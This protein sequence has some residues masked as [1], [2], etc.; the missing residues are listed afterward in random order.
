MIAAPVLAVRL[1][2][3]DEPRRTPRHAHP[4]GQLLGASRGL[5]TVET[6]TARRV[7][8][9]THALWVPGH[10]AH[11]LQSHGPF[12]GWSVYVAESAAALLPRRVVSL[13]MSG[14]LREAAARAAHWR[15]ENWTPAR[16]RLALV[17][18]DEIAAAPDDPIG[19]PTPAD[20]RLLRIADALLRNPADARRLEQWAAWAGVSPRTLSRRF[21]AETG[22]AFA[23][24]RRR[25]RLLRA[26]ELLAEGLSVTAV[27]FD[28]GYE[29]VS[30]FIEAFRGA[31]GVTPSRYAE[32]L[33]G[34]PEEFPFR[35]R[36]APVL[37]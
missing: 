5:I 30:A 25:A 4:E 26:L 24:W 11:G 16:E 2:V 17:I 9:A 20:S 18:L 7:V 28:V 35:R 29:T 6:E 12:H 37:R 1:W 14:L 23:D 3:Q 36:R 8:P 31:F 33:V 21:A 19:L 10:H 27:A 34:P 32:R 15:D 13:R 22:L